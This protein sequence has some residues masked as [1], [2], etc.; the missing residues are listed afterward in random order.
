MNKKQIGTIVYKYSL[1][2]L[3]LAAIAYR[4]GRDFIF[5]KQQLDEVAVSLEDIKKIYPAAAE[6][7]HNRHGAYEAYNSQ[8][9]PLGM[10]LLSSNYSRQYGYAGYVP[11]L[12]G[13]DDNL[14]I[15]KIALLPNNETKDYTRA[16]YRDEFIGKWQGVSLEEAVV[17]P[18]D[19]ISGATHT[20][21]AV[22]AGV[23][24]TAAAVMESD[25]A[26]IS[27]TGAWTTIKDILFLGLLLLS[28]VFAFKKGI[29]RYRSLYLIMVVVIMGLIL[30]KA[31]SMLLLNGWLLNGFSWQANWQTII[32]F[33]LALLISF[34]GKRQFYCNYLCPMGALQ[35]LT[36]RFTPFKTRALPTRFKGISTR[37]VYLL[38]I[39]GALILGFSPELSHLEPFMFFSFRIAGLGLII[40]GI[41]VILLSLFFNR[42]WCSV[43]PTGCFLDTVSYKKVK[44]TKSS[45]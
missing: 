37:E 44:Q 25:A 12:I 13:V 17:Y 41:V 8:G 36:N 45:T 26:A 6:Y 42:P 29:A 32:V 28:L 11:L 30:N 3:I 39:A 19:A 7:S 9:E 18:V 43:C 1:I 2:I 24:Q 15:T 35:E 10:A 22:I 21:E 34:T 27:E 16:V 5:Q 14:L 4:G 20:S 38:L 40:F 23:R 31:L 33:L